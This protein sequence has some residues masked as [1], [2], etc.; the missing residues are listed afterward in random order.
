MISVGFYSPGNHL[1]LPD[2]VVSDSPEDQINQIDDIGENEENNNMENNSIHRSQLYF[3]KHMNS[4]KWITCE[5][6]KEK[7]FKPAKSNVKCLHSKNICSMYTE[8]NDMDPLGVPEELKDLSYVEEQL[9]AVIHP[10]MTVF[11][12]SGHHQFGYRGNIV[13]LPQDVKT[14]AKLLPHTIDSLSSLI[15]IRTRSE[16]NP[17]D[18]HVRAGNCKT[19]S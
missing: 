9:I 11:K 19:I 2:S 12:L 15:T 1:F 4:L 6:C 16:L 17:V 10:M 14:F 5:K 13:N 7:F 3:E 18:F 8:E